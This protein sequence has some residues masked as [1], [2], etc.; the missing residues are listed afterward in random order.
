MYYNLCRPVNAGTKMD[1][2]S[3]KPIGGIVILVIAAVAIGLLV[4]V[5]ADPAQTLI[6][7]LIGIFV[8]VVV[9]DGGKQKALSKR[10][11][12][13]IQ[14]EIESGR[15]FAADVPPEVIGMLRQGQK[16]HAIK[17]LREAT[18][19]SLLDAKNRI[20]EIHL[21][22]TMGQAIECRPRRD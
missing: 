7:M 8:L 13:G 10:L 3:A 6:G 2:R 16:I 21:R 1:K 4:I 19:L 14:Q 15:A 9:L 11:G 18:G 22:L 17:I 5:H 20:D 12:A